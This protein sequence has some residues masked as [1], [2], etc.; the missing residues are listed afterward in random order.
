MADLDDA[1]GLLREAHQGLAPVGFTE[2]VTSA[3]LRIDRAGG[4][5]LV[6]IGL[7]LDRMTTA[8]ETIAMRS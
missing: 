2:D 7:Y 6:A 5:A 3:E 8:L 1:M 4:L